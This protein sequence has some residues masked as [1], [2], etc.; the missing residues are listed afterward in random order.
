MKKI[1]LSLFAVA[2]LGCATTYK[3]PVLS[4][5]EFVGNVQG[6]RENL[7][8]LTKQIL[9]MEG[10]Q[11]QNTDDASGILSTSFRQKRL[12]EQYCDCG[13]TLGLSYIKDNRTI[14]N[15]ALGIIIDENKIIIKANIAGEYLKSVDAVQSI[16][17]DC[18]S[19]G[20]LEKEI[21]EKIQSRNN[22]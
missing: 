3:P 8:K 9:A 15:V 13:T 7:L 2:V 12:N 20:L 11:I 4:P 22:L 17:F 18:V 6:S 19:T 14:T 16:A 21:F 10:Y 5:T 1:L